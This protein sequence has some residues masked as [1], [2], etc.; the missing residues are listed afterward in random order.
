MT[1]ENLLKLLKDRQTKVE[2]LVKENATLKQIQF[3]PVV[4]HNVIPRIGCTFK[5]YWHSCGCCLCWGQNFPS[6]KAG[7]KNDAT[8]QDR[9]GGRDKNCMPA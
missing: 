6:K 4:N 7:H 2:N 9:I 1:N 3:T 8:F 5:C